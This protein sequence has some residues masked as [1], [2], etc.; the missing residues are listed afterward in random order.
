MLLELVGELGEDLGV[1]LVEVLVLGGVLLVGPGLAHAAARDV[2]G[3]SDRGE[4]ARRRGAAEAL[5]RAERL[6][7]ARRGAAWVAQLAALALRGVRG[8]QIECS[9]QAVRWRGPCGVPRQ[10]WGMYG[11]GH[12]EHV[13]VGYRYFLKCVFV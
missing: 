9:A 10:I 11:M 3:R 12:G 1:L 13:P 6:H 5:D 7:F 8:R 2:G 4:P